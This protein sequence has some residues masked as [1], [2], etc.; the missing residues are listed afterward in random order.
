M[1]AVFGDT[2]Y[3]IA[4]SRRADGL[5]QRAR[6]VAQQ[7]GDVRI[8]TSEMVLIEY[9]NEMSKHGEQQRRMAVETVNDLRYDDNVEIVPATSQQFWEA[10]QYYDSHRDQRWS[11]V[12]CVSFMI[13]GEKKIQN[14]LAHDRDFWSAGFRPLLREN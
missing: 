3:W 9:L 8:V 4:I 1:R 5:H 14:A 12:D 6:L 10:V 13:M 2:G 11:L 7:I